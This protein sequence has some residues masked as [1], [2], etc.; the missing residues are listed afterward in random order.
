MSGEHHS[1]DDYQYRPSL[2]RRETLKWAGLL[3]TSVALPGLGGCED[4]SQKALGAAGHWPTL[5]LPPIG[6][7]G[8]GKDPNL[9][10]PPESPWP[11]TLTPVQLTQVAVLSDILLPR[12]GEGEGS[13]PSASEAKV[14]DVI[15]E[16]VSAPYEDQQQDRIRILSALAWIDD[17]AVLR[18][19]TKFL[20]LKHD[21]QLA[22][23]DDIAYDKE[24][25]P[26]P[27]KRVARAFARFRELVMAAYFSS[28]AGIKAIG[29]IG[30]VPIAGDYPGPTPEA[31]EHLDL[32][33]R[34]L[35]LSE[36]A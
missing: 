9:I 11:R 35:G 14:P 16:W 24:Q 20:A 28:P 15:D 6:G 13:T 21:Q 33:L 36:F 8:Y 19:D 31:M 22:I 30:N 1:Q 18:F 7:K 29:Y 26:A 2:T 10:V 5:N 4:A 34:E 25:T 12:E 23:V 27:F 17:E 32:V 3:A